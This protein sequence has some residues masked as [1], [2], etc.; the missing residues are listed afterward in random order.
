M[1]EFTMAIKD[2]KEFEVSISYYKDVVLI[3]FIGN[4]IL[5][6]KPILASAFFA[7]ELD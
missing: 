5:R 4:E 2:T 1:T 7:L 6:A 3:L